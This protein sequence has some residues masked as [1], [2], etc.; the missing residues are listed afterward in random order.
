MSHFRFIKKNIDVSNILADIKEPDWDVAGTLKGAAGDL[1]PYGFLP[2]TMAVVNNTKQG[3][4]GNPKN[5]ELQ[6]NTSMY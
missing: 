4:F 2:L 1:K 3:G 6:Q 5:T